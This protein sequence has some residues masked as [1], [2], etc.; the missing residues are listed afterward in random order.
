MGSFTITSNFTPTKEM[1]S[2][3]SFRC[4]RISVMAGREGALVSGRMIR[5]SI[6]RHIP[7]LKARNVLHNMPG[8]GRKMTQPWASLH[9]KGEAKKSLYF[10]FSP[11][12]SNWDTGDLHYIVGMGH[13]SGKK[14]VY[15]KGWFMPFL[16]FGHAFVNVI[17]SRKNRRPPRYAL[18][19]DN[20]AVIKAGYTPE[21]ERKRIRKNRDLYKRM[22]TQVRYVEAVND[23]R[24]FM[25]PGFLAV[26][27]AAAQAAVKAAQ[28]EANRLFRQIR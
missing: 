27:N 15:N 8:E 1:I 16:E 20:A 25:E 17:I 28:K 18:P 6:I 24:G 2:K 14:G 13:G 23:G 11:K 4:K 5:K 22:M 21:S 19:R 3:Y 7:V 10:T 9:P 12:N 26:K